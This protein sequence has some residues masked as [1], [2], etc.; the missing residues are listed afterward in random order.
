MWSIYWWHPREA[1]D[2]YIEVFLNLG[3]LGIVLFGN[4]LVTGYRTVVSAFRRNAEEGRLRLAYFVVAVA[5][6]FAESAFGSLNP[7]W[8]FFLLATISVPGGWIKMKPRKTVTATTI[9]PEA[10]VPCLEQV[11][12]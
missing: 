2:G 3:W 7:I 8:I 10:G 1:H 6:N 12:M 4:V 5:Y 9:I 11:P